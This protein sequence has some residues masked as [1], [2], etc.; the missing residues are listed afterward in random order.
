MDR[1][2]TDSLLTDIVEPSHHTTQKLDKDCSL[3]LPDILVDFT[4][5]GQSGDMKRHDVLHP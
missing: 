5:E 4:F 2:W 3:Q 1:F